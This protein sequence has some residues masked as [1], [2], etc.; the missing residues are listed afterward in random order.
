MNANPTVGAAEVAK[1]AGEPKSKPV[2]KRRPKKDTLKEIYE[3]RFTVELSDLELDVCLCAFE[4][5]AK[6]LIAESYESEDQQFHFG[7]I[8]RLALTGSTLRRAASRIPEKDVIFHDPMSDLL[9]FDRGLF[10]DIR[11]SPEEE[12][13]A[14]NSVTLSEHALVTL[15]YSV[16]WAME[17]G[18][19]LDWRTD[20]WK[21]T[22]YVYALGRVGAKLRA[23]TSELTCMWQL[24]RQIEYS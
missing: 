13:T 8:Y 14:T 1:F 7:M 17:R 4:K 18:A 19:H 9:Q 22:N 10:G 16:E 24:S 3:D 2:R 20:R 21:R 11:Y 23:F 12:E 6:S 5:S 15:L